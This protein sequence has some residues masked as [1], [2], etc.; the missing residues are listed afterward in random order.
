MIYIHKQVHHG[1]LNTYLIDKI[2]A[3]IEK[4]VRLSIIFFVLLLSKL[5]KDKQYGTEAEKEEKL[6]STF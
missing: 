3:K 6:S 5:K 2:D 1:I 4:I